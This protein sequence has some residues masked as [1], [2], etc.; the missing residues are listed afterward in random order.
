MKVTLARASHRAE[1]KTINML[2]AGQFADEL[3]KLNTEL[4]VNEE[5]KDIT[6]EKDDDEECTYIVSVNKK[7]RAVEIMIYDYYVE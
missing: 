4:P 6:W 3:L 1:E 7:T 2:W 5:S